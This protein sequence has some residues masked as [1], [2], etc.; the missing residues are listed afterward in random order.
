M[1]LSTQ[2]PLSVLDLA[3]RRPGTDPGQPFR[4]AVE[5]AQTAEASGYTGLWYAEHHNMASIASSA[6]SVLMAHVAAHTERI[7]VGAG[8]VMLSNHP[9]LL[10]AEQFGTLE[11][12]HPGRVNLG[13]GRAPG[14]DQVT[15]R[16]LR[17]GPNAAEHFP[18]DVVE[19]MGYLDDESRIPGVDAYPGRGS[20]VPVTILGSSLFGAQLAAQLGLPYAFAS[21]FAPA[22]L[23]Q[24]LDVYVREFKPSARLEAP[25][26]IVAV[27]VLATQDP[28]EA[29]RRF[30]AV[31]RERVR[32]ML[33]RGRATPFT[34]DEVDL[35]LETPAGRQVL[36]SMSFSAIGTP[37]RVATQ[38]REMAASAGAAE[39][40][41]VHHALDQATRLDSV[42]LTAAA[43]AAGGLS[44]G[45]A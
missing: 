3:P 38:L 36:E 14:T 6:T 16:A 30:D 25:K 24:A 43:W 33:G 19:L 20:H 18:S 34:E 10:I 28:A 5:L 4:D 40:I 32:D 11:A 23:E 1:T 8:G 39:L 31:G 41:T 37:D 2:P 27:G 45:L 42:R 21:H 22:A 15:T 7:T 13:V 35:I 12:M 17:R 44:G 26:P 9:P 29:V